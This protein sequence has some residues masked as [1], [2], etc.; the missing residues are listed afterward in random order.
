MEVGFQWWVEPDSAV[1]TG[2]V[3]GITFDVQVCGGFVGAT[4]AGVH[5]HVFLGCPLD[6]QRALPAIGLK[7]NVPGREY[8]VTVFEPLALSAGL[9]QLTGQEHLV[10]FDGGVVLE[11]DCEVEVTLCKHTPVKT[12]AQT[13]EIKLSKKRKVSSKKN[14]KQR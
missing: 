5:P 7:Q 1:L 6:E 10:L 14:R 12:K 13:T 3:G 9:A 8:L 4:V 2:F 11:F